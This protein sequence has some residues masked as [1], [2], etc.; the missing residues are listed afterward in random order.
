MTALPQIFTTTS[1]NR[2]WLASVVV[3]EEKTP[4]V[5]FFRGLLE[6]QV[7]RKEESEL[8]SSTHTYIETNI[9]DQPA[10]ME[11]DKTSEGDEPD[12]SKF[13]AALQNLTDKYCN[14]DTVSFYR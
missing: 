4:P 14:V 7:Q 5:S 2:W 8:I 1:E 13:F 3:G 11:E 10:V 12:T 9:Q 6:P